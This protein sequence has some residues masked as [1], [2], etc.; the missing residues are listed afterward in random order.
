MKL[1]LLIALAAMPALAQDQP[2]PPLKPFKT[3]DLR[4]LDPLIAK[5]EGCA[6]NLAKAVALDG[7]EQRKYLTELFVYGCI[8]EAPGAYKTN[9]LEFKNFGEGANSVLYAQCLS[10]R[11]QQRQG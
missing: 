3:P 5:D 2:K 6:K 1:A 7:L 4:L 11:P 9:I 8:R 10:H